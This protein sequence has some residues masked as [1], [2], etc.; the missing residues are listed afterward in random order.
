[1]NTLPMALSYLGGMFLLG[2]LIASI[3]KAV[4]AFLNGV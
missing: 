2:V 4:R 1:M 3:A